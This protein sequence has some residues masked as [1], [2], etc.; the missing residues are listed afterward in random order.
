MTET[1]FLMQESGLTADEWKAYEALGTTGKLL[2]AV[3]KAMGLSEQALK[4]KVEAENARISFEKRY[5]DEF[6]PEMKNVTQEALRAKGEAAKMKA[7]LDAARQYGIVPDDPA[8][9]AEPPRAPGSPDPSGLTREDLNRFSSAQSRTLITLNDLN[10]DHFRLFGSPLPN[11]QELV[12]E[13]E[14]QRMLGNKNFT[15]KQAWEQKFD[16]PK[17]REE[18]R[19]AEEQKKID[20]AV[21][22]DR[23]IQ[24]EKHG[25]NP[26]LRSGKESR[27]SSYKPTDAAGNKEPWKASHSINERNTPWRQ[28]ATAKIREAM[29]S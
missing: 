22:A 7:Q 21:S 12:D 25:S 29:A 11:T 10:A 20:A 15:L 27:F 16:V 2:N 24:A 17:K 23:K 14:R 3:K 13:A 4:D 26:N 1:E 6:V 19:A 5:N 9:P 18:I 8:L 28:K